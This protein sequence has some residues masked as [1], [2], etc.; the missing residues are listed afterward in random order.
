MP[1]GARSV[2]AN[3]Q[4]CRELLAGTA[5]A[6]LTTP[7]L[8][9]KPRKLNALARDSLPDPIKVERD[10]GPTRTEYL[11]HNGRFTSDGVRRRS[12]GIDS[13]WASKRES[14]LFAPPTEAQAMRRLILLSIGLV[15]PSTAGAQSSKLTRAEAE[16]TIAAAGYESVRDL[17]LDDGFW[18]ADARH[19]DGQWIDVRVHPETGK[20]YAENTV[21]KLNAEEVG[22]RLAAA[23]YGHV[24]DIDFDDCVWTAYARNEAGGNVDVAVDPDDG[25]VLSERPDD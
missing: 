12:N 3:A 11:R 4:T 9:R 23:G 15:V 2:I 16:A 25:T 18:E 7:M 24:R 20:V 17:E 6:A 22:K 13:R 1:C 19:A 10:H 8:P 21:P 5:S 14:T